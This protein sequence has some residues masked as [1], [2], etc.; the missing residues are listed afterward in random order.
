MCNLFFNEDEESD[1]DC[2]MSIMSSKSFKINIICII[3]L[4]HDSIVTK[5]QN[6]LQDLL[7]IFET[8]SAWFHTSNLKIIQTI[9]IFDKLL[10]I[11]YNNVV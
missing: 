10:K 9:M 3:M 7:C 11:A 2:Q 4:C 6:W 8:D 1:S 5:Y